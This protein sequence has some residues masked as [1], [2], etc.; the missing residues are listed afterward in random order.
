MPT[1]K[2]PWITAGYQ[3]FANEGPAGLK[4]EV[5]ARL[6]EKS[7]SSFYHHF[8]DLELFTDCLLERHL[9]QARILAERE[10]QCKNIDPDLIELLVDVKTDLL[11][12]RQLR[13]N[14]QVPIYKQCFEKTNQF[15]EG[16]FMDIWSKDIGLPDQPLLASHVF[17]MVLENFYFQITEDHLNQEWLSDYFKNIRS[18][19]TDLQKSKPQ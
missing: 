19:V 10:K 7:K 3:L 12:N 4:V 2:Q 8:A 9:E 16:A 13:F 1:T 6:V 14:R 17:D 5:I 18:M 15:I 11:F